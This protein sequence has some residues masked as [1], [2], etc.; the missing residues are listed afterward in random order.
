MSHLI[1]S[2]AYKNRLR[3]LP[4]N[5]KLLLAIVLLILSLISPWLVQLLIGFWLTIAI[6]IYA[7]IPQRTYLRLLSLPLG[8]SLISLPAF[9]ISGVPWDKKSIIQQDI[10]QGMGFYLGYLY[11]YISQTGMEQ[12]GF[13][14]PR[15]WAM[16]NCLYFLILTTPFIEILQVFRQWRCPILLT[17]LLLLMYRFIFSL[18]EVAQE[19]WTAQNSRCG[20]QSWSRGMKSIG[21]LGGQ[22]FQRTLNNYRQISISL[23]A[24]GFQGSL[25]MSSSRSYQSQRRYIFEALFGCILLIILNL[26][27]N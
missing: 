23:E 11:L 8:F 10:W 7:G 9:L 18:L 19:I 16:T 4:P 6:T 17:D 1:D 13:L 15:I 24:R 26:V 5:H 25:K 3:W 22:L 2:L 20:Y 14:F 27:I 12:V 21:I